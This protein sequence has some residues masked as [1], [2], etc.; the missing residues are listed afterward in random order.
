MRMRTRNQVRPARFA[1]RIGKRGDEG[2]EEEGLGWQM[3]EW[4]RVVGYGEWE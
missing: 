4:E 1:M 3:E 2:R